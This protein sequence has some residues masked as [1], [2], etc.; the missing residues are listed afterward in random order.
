MREL[1]IEECQTISGAG[2]LDGCET[3]SYSEGIAAGTAIG[4]ATGGG[5][6]AVVGAALGASFVVGW[7]TGVYV[8][9]LIGQCDS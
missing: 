2:N 7:N 8:N 5:F 9:N 1:T 4:A 6:G 3:G